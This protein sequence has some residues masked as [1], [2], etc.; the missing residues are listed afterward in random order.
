MNVDSGNVTFFDTNMTWF[1]NNGITSHTH[2]FRNFKGGILTV[3]QATN[4][5]FLKGVMNVGTNN[6]IV[7]KNI[8][9][10]I[11]IHGG[12]T[13]TISEADNATNHRFASQPVF[14]IVTSFTHV[15]K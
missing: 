3:Q 4:D 9:S 14:G 7:W 11:S 15:G 5:V 6:R 8:P 13:I 1:N 10:T 2:E 12:K